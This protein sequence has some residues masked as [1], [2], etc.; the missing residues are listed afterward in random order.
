MKTTIFFQA[1]QALRG[2]LKAAVRQQ[3]TQQ[4]LSR[5][6]GGLTIVGR[7][8]LFHWRNDGARFQ[9]Q[10]RRRHQN[11]I[12]RHIQISVLPTTNRFDKLIDNERQRH[13]KNIEFRAPN[14]IEQQIEW[15]AETVDRDG[16]AKVQRRVA[17]DSAC[18]FADSAIGHAVGY[19]AAHA[20]IH[21]GQRGQIRN[22]LVYVIASH[23]GGAHL[24]PCFR[25][26]LA[27]GAPA[28]ATDHR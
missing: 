2:F 8:V 25:L 12:A 18:V 26:S 23:G 21:R 22:R 27:D 28:P 4:R 7:L 10:Q 11:E 3:R 19:A 16:V 1:I 9:L 20:A 6:E 5:I 24:R 13:L 14:E 17:A 15:A